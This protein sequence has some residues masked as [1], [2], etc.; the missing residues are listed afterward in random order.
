[1]EK[2]IFF[3]K[4]LYILG[5]LLLLYPAFNGITGLVKDP[6]L[7]GGIELKHDV[8]FSFAGWWNGTWQGPK[9]EYLRENFGCRNYLVRLHNEIDYRIFHKG[10][11]RN[12]VIGKEDYLYEKE[13]ILTY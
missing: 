13:Y 12:L 6:K 9:E 4:S 3:K 5:A 10:H 7:K 1:M 2:K 8:A 11:N